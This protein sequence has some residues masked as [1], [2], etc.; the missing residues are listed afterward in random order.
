MSNGRKYEIYLHRD[1]F[2]WVIS[3]AWSG[4]TKVKPRCKTLVFSTIDLAQLEL[5][6]LQKIRI[7][8]KYVMKFE[9]IN[10][11]EI[12]KITKIT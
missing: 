1:L 4:H 10:N 8:H 2:D 5:K 9:E 6:K 3:L 11:N 12:T 7:S